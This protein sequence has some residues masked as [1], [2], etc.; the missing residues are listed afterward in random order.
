VVR[1][2]LDDIRD[3]QKDLS[4]GQK[5][6]LAFARLFFHRPNFVVNPLF[7]NTFLWILKSTRFFSIGVGRVHQR[8]FP[9]RRARFV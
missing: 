5:Q 6:K 1:P 2:K 4:P 9:G 8:H 3:W 7:P